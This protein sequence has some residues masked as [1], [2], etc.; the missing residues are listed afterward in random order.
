MIALLLRVIPCAAVYG[1]LAAEFAGSWGVF[2]G[3]CVAGAVGLF[4]LLVLRE[5]RS[6]ACYPMQKIGGVK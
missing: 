4:L 2:V 5:R 3:L 1:I 6:R